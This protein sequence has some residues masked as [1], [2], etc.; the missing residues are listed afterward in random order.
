MRYTRSRGEII[1][2]Q[3]STGAPACTRPGDIGLE[4]PLQGRLLV[5]DLA[6]TAISVGEIVGK[7]G[8]GPLLALVAQIG[9]GKLLGEN[10]AQIVGVDSSSWVPPWP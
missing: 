5:Q 7:A 4:H 8:Q 2:L 1:R 3:G 9:Q 10:P 6:E